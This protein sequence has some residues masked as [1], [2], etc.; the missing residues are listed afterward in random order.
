MK[1]T[2][3]VTIVLFSLNLFA[4]MNLLEKD[5]SEIENLVRQEGEMFN[6]CDVDF[7]AARVELKQGLKTME[8]T[9]QAEGQ[10]Y[11]R[12]RNSVQWIESEFCQFRKDTSDKNQWVL[13]Y[14]D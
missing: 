3:I 8:G 4:S 7:S 9:V 2:V 1:K 5:I 13:H 12:C 6:I 10:I 11:I 14:C